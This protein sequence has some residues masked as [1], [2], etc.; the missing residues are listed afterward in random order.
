MRYTREERHEIYQKALDYFKKETP[1]DVGICTVL[2]KQLDLEHWNNP[3]ARLDIENNFPELWEYKLNDSMARHIP[4]NELWWNLGMRGLSKRIQA[5]KYAV[6]KT[7]PEKPEPL[8]YEERRRLYREALDYF[9][10][11]WAGDGFC[12][13]FSQ[14][15]GVRNIEHTLP[16]LIEARSAS[17]TANNKKHAHWWPLNE[18][19]RQERIKAL[20]YALKSLEWENWIEKS[21]AEVKEKKEELLSELER[22]EMG[23]SF[24]NPLEDRI[25]IKPVLYID[26]STLRRNRYYQ[27]R[28]YMQGDQTIKVICDLYRIPE[29][30]TPENSTWIRLGGEC[31]SYYSKFFYDRIPVMIQCPNCGARN[32][33]SDWDMISNEYRL[34]KLECPACHTEI[35]VEK[36]TVEECLKRI[37]K[38]EK[39]IPLSEE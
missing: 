17:K 1:L 18:E 35:E 36:E 5:L 13:Y 32:I 27:Q 33:S 2:I 39:D 37:G 21:K 25:T 28:Q 20:K 11:R 19:G 7:A 16:E 9:E 30:L 23:L 38:S 24:S 15:Y 8:P 3:V 26:H 34:R 22:W 14:K 29:Y 10:N 6:E 31:E 4:V 12:C